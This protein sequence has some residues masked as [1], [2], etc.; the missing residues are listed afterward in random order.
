MKT[1][2]LTLILF[3]LN[4]K[5]FAYIDPGAGGLIIQAIIGGIAAISLFFK[6]IKLKIKSLLIKLFKKRK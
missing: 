2:F 6:K 5:A 3:F 1:F 4:T